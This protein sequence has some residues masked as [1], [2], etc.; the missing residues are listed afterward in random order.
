VPAGLTPRLGAAPG[1]VSPYKAGCQA[2]QG[3]AKVTT[4]SYGPADS[5]TTVV[6]MGD[7]HAMQL[8]T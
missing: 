4:C 1:D 3:S 6:L 7:S 2:T 8:A 5:S